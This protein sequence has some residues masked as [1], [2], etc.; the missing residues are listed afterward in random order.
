MSF[1][2]DESFAHVDRFIF[3]PEI[4]NIIDICLCTLAMTRHSAIFRH[5]ELKLKLDNSALILQ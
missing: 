1:Y 5:Q 4:L 3:M 2:L